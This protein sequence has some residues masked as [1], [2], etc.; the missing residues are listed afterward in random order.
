MRLEDLKRL[1]MVTEEA[2]ARIIGPIYLASPYYHE[3]PAMVNARVYVNTNVAEYYVRRGYPVYSPCAY[4]RQWQGNTLDRWAPP[5][6]WYEFDLKFLE[7]CGAMVI[8]MLPGVEES[9]G[10]ALELEYAQATRKPVYRLEPEE[11]PEQ[12]RAERE[13]ALQ[14][15]RMVH[16]MGGVK[17]D[18]D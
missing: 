15:T 14:L 2:L 3:D 5:G 1:P 4:T 17:F 16:E 7:G 12:T 6:G 11:W 13:E 18:E 10:V 8:L 9:K